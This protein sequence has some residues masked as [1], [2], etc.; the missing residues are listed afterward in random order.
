M[1]ASIRSLRNGILPVDDA[2]RDDLVIGD[3]VTVSALVASSTYNWAIVFA[4]ESVAGLPSVATFTGSAGDVSPGSFTVDNPGP[5]L[6]RLI[7][8]AGLAT[9]DTQYV[10]LRALTGQ[11]SR[12]VSAGERR[13]ASGL[14]PV[15]V[16][17]EGW[18]NEQNFNLQTLENI[19][20]A[21]ER[22]IEIAVAV[23]D[24]S[25][26]APDVFTPAD[27]T[28]PVGARVS[29]V[30]V[31]VNL[32]WDGAGMVFSVGDGTTSGRYAAAGDSNAGAAAHFI[33]DQWDEN[34]SGAPIV[35]TL[36][37]DYTGAGTTGSVTVVVRYV[38]EP[39]T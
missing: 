4:P 18:A 12:L 7:T 3:I 14:I 26:A 19:A 13:D 28:I 9:E 10:R 32:V 1:P 17:V 39:A 34:V 6:I 11:G 31:I 36:T 21:G 22:F 35:P 8:D 16:S 27:A 38:E 2:S 20:L 25:G 37:V 23:A 5:Y 15:D 24:L 29:G 30:T 33:I